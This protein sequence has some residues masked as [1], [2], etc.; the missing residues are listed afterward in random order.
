MTA[1]VLVAGGAGY[2]GSHM[3]KKLAKAGY[4]I[5]T[6]DNLSVGHRDAVL[7]GD[8]VHADLLDRDAMARLF[9]SRRFDLVIHFAASAYVGESVTNPRKYYTNNV[10]GTLNLVHAMLDAG[11]SRMIFSST[12]ASYGIARE[13]P[14]TEA[15]PQAPINPYGQTKLIIEGV[16]RDYAAAYGL[17][18]IA[19][20]YFNAAGC[21]REGDLRERHDP[22]PH[23]IPLILR[24]ALRVR[25]GGDRLASELAV[26]GDDYPTPDG[27]CVR[28]YIHVED[29]CRAHLAAAERVL[30]K[31]TSGFEVFNLG[32]ARGVSILELINAVREITGA[33]IVHRVL[34]RRPGD[35]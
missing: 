3:L 7:H 6:V 20:R 15:H 33:D 26:F 1:S 28:D 5:T 30:S 24:E 23:I 32:N 21:D 11:V 8:F 17:T 22:E 29:L 27:T 9:T 14:I 4:A 34:P 2:I 25:A 18:S 12:C 10:M 13:V 16:L 31:A 19:L 35:P